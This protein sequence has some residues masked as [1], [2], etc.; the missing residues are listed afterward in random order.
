MKL[1]KTDFEGLLKDVD[2]GAVLNAD[3]IA[4][5]AYKKRKRANEE[6]VQFKDKIKKID[7][8][9]LEI[10]NVLKAIAEKI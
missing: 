6:F 4:L 1:E 8:D 7:D 5:E 2:S 9:I 10:K 3:N